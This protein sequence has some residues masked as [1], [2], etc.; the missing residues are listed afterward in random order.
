[1]LLKS[2]ELFG[3]KSFADRTKI[4]FDKGITGIVGPNGCGKSNVIDAIRWVLGEQSTKNLRSDKMD[5]VIFNG[6][7]KR[8]R[9][10][11]AEVSITFENTN[12]LLPT[13]FSTLT[14]TR[15]LFREGGSEYFLNN[16]PCR[17]KDIDS[18][19]LDTGIGPDS[20]AIIELKMVDELL[21]DKQNTRR[22][23]FDEAAGIAKYKVRKKETFKKLEATDQDLIRVEDLL[24]EIDK[25]LKN[26]EKQAKKTEK[27][28]EL[29]K[30]YQFVSQQY[31]FLKTQKLNLAY[32]NFSQQ[33]QDLQDQVLY[34]QT[35]A[36]QVDT[37]LQQ[38]HK[39]LLE[40]EELLVKK[41]HVLNEYQ[42]TIQKIEQEKKIRN[43][44]LKFLNA[45]SENLK[46]NL[47]KLQLNKM[48]ILDELQELENQLDQ[49]NE[50]YDTKEFLLKEIEQNL[51]YD[52]HLTQTKKIHSEEL[53]AKTTK[54]QK[55][56]D[57][58]EKELSLCKLKLENIDNQL[59]NSQ[60]SQQDQQE[61]SQQILLQINNTQEKIQLTQ[62]QLQQ[63]NENLQQALQQKNAFEQ[64]IDELKKQILDYQVLIDKKNNEYQFIR[65]LIEN[66]EGFPESIKFLNKNNQWASEPALL[67]D[68]FS[69]EDL[70]RSALEAFLEPWLHCYV[71]K[72]YIEAYKAIQLL[73]KNK[74]GKATLFILEEIEKTLPYIQQTDTSVPSDLVPIISL[75]NYEPHYEPLAKF[76]F[77]NTYITHDP[78]AT[79]NPNYIQVY[80]D[81][82]SIT[83]PTHLTGGSHGLFQSQ[84]IGRKKQLQ[85]ILN[86]IQIIQ[87]EIEKTNNQLLLLNDSIK[88]L[89]INDLQSLIKDKNQQLQ[90]AQTQLQLLEY[91]IQ[92]S[93]KQSL[94]TQHQLQKLLQSQQEI[95]KQLKELNDSHE[96]IF[97]ELAELEQNYQK[98]LKDYNQT[99]DRLNLSQQ[100][101]NNENIAFIE[102]KNAVQ[103]IRQ[104]IKFQ[105]EQSLKLEEQYQH[106]NIELEQIQIELDKLNSHTDDDHS[107]LIELYEIKEV[108]Q[109]HYDNQLQAVRDTKNNI[110]RNESILKQL[111]NEKD[112]LQLSIQDLQ[113]KQNEIHIEIRSIKDRLQVEFQIDIENL[114][115]NELFETNIP[116]PDADELYQKT[117]EIRN[118]ISNF[119]EVN[120]MA[121]EAYNEMK[122][123][124]DFIISQRTDILKAKNDLLKTIQEI[125]KNAKEQFLEAFTTIRQNF[126][127]VFRSLFTNEDTCDLILLDPEHPTESPIEIIAKPKGKRPLNINQLSGGEKTL[128]ATSLLFAIYLY[129]PAPFCIFDEVDAPLDDANIDK[130]NNI[131]REFSNE[132]QFIIVTHNKRTM[133]TTHTIYGVTMEEMG[134]SKILPV[135]LKELNLP[136]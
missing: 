132:S 57:S 96:Q 2:L 44:R 61:N 59:L 53:Y 41:H 107:Q 130:F 136:N 19:L 37:T 103:S 120:P 65:S 64:Q 42:E 80:Y 10:N 50:I 68:I 52:K 17:L 24:N 101:F 90:Q 118:K 135:S 131:I 119:G 116:L 69:C 34:N 8:K 99:Q 33:I 121:I 67:S 91:Q 5:E 133:T 1:M 35:Q 12:K 11:I 73:Q 117:I 95:N 31:A 123:R 129:K 6:T 87:Q 125:D 108:A 36:L 54:K 55:Q 109:S 38:L 29:K 102:A 127:R 100:Q 88:S 105:R 84:T 110:L 48:L 85:A 20:Y 16:I 97:N 98:A 77:H 58:I 76:L 79:P 49:A 72:D 14:I 86:D 78:H 106:S 81:G 25:N 43:E 32:Q 134:I 9:S 83:F 74:A 21:N 82:S 56:L 128:T 13:E 63:L 28:F 47:T 4:F 39:Q 114:D 92:Q 93:D 62:N 71:V 30:E 70:Y 111:R 89:P 60:Q 45:R 40:Q 46:A 18:L 23:L 112:Q 22:E 94:Q 51:E 126:M 3:F 122:Q 113:L 104:Q 66:L 27:Y 75:L 124:Y 15:K 26:L 7:Q 115:P